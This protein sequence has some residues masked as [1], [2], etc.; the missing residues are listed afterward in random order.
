MDISQRIDNEFAIVLWYYNHRL[1]KEEGY[2]KHYLYGDIH[3]WI[4]ALVDRSETMGLNKNAPVIFSGHRSSDRVIVDK[5]VLAKPDAMNRNLTDKLVGLMFSDWAHAYYW[6]HTFIAAISKNY[7]MAAQTKAFAAQVEKRIREN[8]CNSKFLLDSSRYFDKLDYHELAYYFKSFMSPEE[9]GQYALGHGL[10]LDDQAACHMI[11]QIVL[12]RKHEDAKELLVDILIHQKLALPVNSLDKT[13]ATVKTEDQFYNAIYLDMLLCEYSWADAKFMQ[14]NSIRISDLGRFRGWYTE[15]VDL[16]YHEYSKSTYTSKE[17]RVISYLD[18]F[19][20]EIGLN[21]WE[22]ALEMGFTMLQPNGD[23]IA[24]ECRRLSE[25]AL[26]GKVLSIYDKANEDGCLGVI[27]GV[28]HR[29]AVNIKSDTTS[30]W[31]FVYAYCSIRR[32]DYPNNLD[33]LFEL[34]RDIDAKS[35]VWAMYHDLG[36]HKGFGVEDVHAA[37]K[38][39]SAV[40]QNMVF[41]RLL[42]ESESLDDARQAIRVWDSQQ[43]SNASIENLKLFFKHIKKSSRGS[44]SVTRASVADAY[45]Q[46]LVDSGGMAELDHYLPLC[47]YTKIPNTLMISRTGSKYAVNLQGDVLLYKGYY[48]YSV[49]ADY[50]HKMSGFPVRSPMQ[51]E[52]ATEIN[53]VEIKDSDCIP[54]LCEG[55]L[56]KNK[57]NGELASVSQEHLIPYYWCYNRKCVFP[58]IELVHGIAHDI[59]YSSYLEACQTKKY[60]ILKV[61]SLMGISL[62]SSSVANTVCAAMNSAKKFFEHLKCRDCGEFLSPL[63]TSNYAYYQV[64]L[65]KCSKCETEVYLSHCLN[66]NCIDV[67]DSRDCGKCPNDWY[68]CKS[69]LACCDDEKIDNRSHIKKEIGQQEPPKKGH[70]GRYLYCPQ[71][72]RQL[73]RSGVIDQ[74]K[75]EKITE[76]FEKASKNLVRAKGKGVG[77]WYLVNLGVYAGKIKRGFPIEELID[78]LI[79]CG[80][81][82]SKANTY[83]KDEPIYLIS[84]VPPKGILNRGSFTHSDVKPDCRIVCSCGYT[85]KV[86]YALVSYHNRRINP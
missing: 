51:T 21:Q 19:E 64:H 86:K 20:C 6:E 77:R 55:R 33:G 29:L 83:T 47:N 13:I 11:S 80:L 39:L 65:Y 28:I 73:N 40:E 1:D 32:G 67:I 59:E 62:N 18:L 15:Q 52:T 5:L 45:I 30:A 72:G 57:N 85:Q 35:V 12:E 63:K 43:I 66:H 81:S 74:D 34:V 4:S 17:A 2:I 27:D 9:Y 25:E 8:K 22:V 31:R 42:A 70:K 3:F 50:Q 7:D 76:F 38:R 24:Q 14:K 56:V 61:L 53:Q 41:N 10:P 75:I 79:T 68:I 37:L 48:G 49:V 84:D 46:V 54:L 44:N 16:V 69:C 71:C 23:D 36:F 78:W 60:A 26:W 58:T 82:V